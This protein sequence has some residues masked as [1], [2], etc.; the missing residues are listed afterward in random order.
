[1]LSS[2]GWPPLGTQIRMTLNFLRCPGFCLLS[3]WV[4]GMR[5]VW[6]VYGRA[7][8]GGG[9]S[10]CGWDRSS[11]KRG[12]LHT[13]GH[14]RSQSAIGTV[15]PRAS[16]VLSGLQVPGLQTSEKQSLSRGHKRPV[17]GSPKQP[18]E[19]RRPKVEAAGRAIQ[20]YEVALDPGSRGWE[21]P[22]TGSDR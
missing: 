17:R 20:G 2:P 15:L 16:T 8:S 1:M 3:A 4:T 6:L 13:Q 18:R 10:P 5:C 19:K 12:L 11:A 9:Q 14:M 21:P 7:V 22:G